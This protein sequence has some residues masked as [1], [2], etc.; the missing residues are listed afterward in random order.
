[1]REQIHD[2]VQRALTPDERALEKIRGQGKLH[3]DSVQP[4]HPL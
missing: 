2:A 3:L 4:R 1:M